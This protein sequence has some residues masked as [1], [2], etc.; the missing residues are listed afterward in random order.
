MAVPVPVPDA[1]A[2]FGAKCSDILANLLFGDN[3][4]APQGRLGAGG[5]DPQLHTA[6]EA[7]TPPRAM[8]RDVLEGG[9][10]GLKGGEGGLA[11]TPLLR[12][13]PY[14]PRRKRA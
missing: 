8:T 3:T 2:K 14:G 12:E 9:C 7:L 4:A 11:G 5:A 10:G 13:S 1:S 6:P